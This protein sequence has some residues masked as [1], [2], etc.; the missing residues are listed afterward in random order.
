MVCLNPNSFSKIVVVSSNYFFNSEIN[1][2]L[3]YNFKMAEYLF[4]YSKQ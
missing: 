2:W 4:K 3:L 1:G